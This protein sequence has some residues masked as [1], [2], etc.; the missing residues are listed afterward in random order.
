MPLDLRQL[1]Y[2]VAVA[3]ERHI[4]RAA[5]RLGMQQPPLSQQIR[6]IEERL[7][8]VLFR[9]LPRGVEPT[10]AGLALLEDARTILARLDQAVERTRSVARG[11][12]GRLQVGMSPTGP[13]L[14]FVPKLI[15]TFRETWP[16]VALGLEEMLSR[17]LLEGLRQ[18][19]LDAVLLRAEVVESDGLVVRRL[20]EEVL[21]AALPRANPL[22][23]RGRGRTLPLAALATEPFIVFG[24]LEGPGLYDATVRSCVS[25]GFTPRITQ[26]APRITST[27]GLVAAGLGVALVPESMQRLRMDGVAYVRIAAPIM[28]PAVLNLATRRGDRSASVRNFMTLAQR[29]ASP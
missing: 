20:V 15:R 7:G 22:A 24:R 27:L 12:Q 18:E 5:S 14:P 23:R 8:V 16:L 13:F 9:R 29:L 26:E 6:A 1:R 3:E 25:A 2:F 4:T 21:V 28:A 17:A 11:E 19:Q 10:E